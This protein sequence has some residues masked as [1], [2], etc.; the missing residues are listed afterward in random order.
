MRIYFSARDC[1]RTNFEVI[2]FVNFP[3]VERKATDAVARL[4]EKCGGEA[5]YLR[6]SKLIYLADRK[7]ILTRGIPIVGGHYFSMRKGPVIGEVMDFVKCR[8][9]PRWKSTISP[10]KGNTLNLI[11]KPQYDSLTE[12]E[13]N[14]LDSVVSEHLTRTTDELVGWCHQNCPE[15]E[16][17]F[18]SRKPIELES[19]LRNEGKSAEQIQRISERAK[20]LVELNEILA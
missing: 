12:S 18:F 4:I 1:R 10:R 14:I 6:I 9:A 17:V 2:F 16:H 20:E 19:I 3:T 8:N 5:D 13:L 11:A 15:Y 7:S